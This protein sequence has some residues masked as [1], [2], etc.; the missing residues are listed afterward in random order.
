[1]TLN[2]QLSTDEKRFLLATGL[3]LAAFL[4]VVL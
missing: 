1:M 2:L 4:A 3:M